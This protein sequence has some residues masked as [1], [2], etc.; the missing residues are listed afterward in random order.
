MLNEFFI[1]NEGL[2][3]VK[4]SFSVLLDGAHLS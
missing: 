1:I 2:I 3:I 4:F